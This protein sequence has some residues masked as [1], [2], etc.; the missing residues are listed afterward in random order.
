MIFNYIKYVFLFFSLVVGN[1]SYADIFFQD[2]TSKSYFEYFSE[3]TSQDFKNIEKSDDYKKKLVVGTV[4]VKGDN[5]LGI[6][7]NCE[8]G[9]KLLFN[10]WDNNGI[11][12]GYILSNIYYRGICVKKNYSKAQKYLLDSA[13]KGF[14]LSQRI[15]GLA[16][17]NCNRCEMNDLFEK[18]IDKSIYWLKKSAE[19]GDVES[20]EKLA[21]IFSSDKYDM[22]DEEKAFYWRSKSTEPT[23]YFSAKIQNFLLLAIFYE[24][25]IGTE[26]NLTQAYKCYVLSGSAGSEDKYRLEKMM[27]PEKIKEGDRL[28]KEWIN[29]IRTSIATNIILLM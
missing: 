11:D 22:Y 16:Y 20:T 2:P 6:S 13:N 15:L 24:K 5:D 7:Q 19:A 12:A 25:G 18:D 27:T 14:I 23:S 8:K 28:A 3:L 26:K 1:I 21:Y 10:V 29:I 17:L 4:Y 9:K